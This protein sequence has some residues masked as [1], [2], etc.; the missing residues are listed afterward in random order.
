MHCVLLRH[1]CTSSLKSWA[2]VPASARW[3]GGASLLFP[4]GLG[5][6][7]VRLD[8]TSVPRRRDSSCGCSHPPHLPADLV[9]QESIPKQPGDAQMSYMWT[10]YL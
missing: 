7:G 6:R 8:P 1:G 2:W 5:D 9:G 10:D 3:G 4:W